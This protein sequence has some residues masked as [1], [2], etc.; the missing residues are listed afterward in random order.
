MPPCEEERPSCLGS[1][2]RGPDKR[3]GFWKGMPQGD[4]GKGTQGS[5]FQCA[6]PQALELVS[7]KQQGEKRLAM[8]LII[9]KYKEIE[10]MQLHMFKTQDT[11]TK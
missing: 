4:Q 9:I 10:R 8:R 7:V 5:T 3:L 2:F 11:S 6:N 1:T